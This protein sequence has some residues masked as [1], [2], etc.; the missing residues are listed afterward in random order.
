MVV[1][2]FQST[3]PTW[4]FYLPNSACSLALSYRYL[5]RSSTWKPWT[6][7]GTGRLKAVAHTLAKA[8]WR[9]STGWFRTSPR[10]SMSWIN[11]HYNVGTWNVGF[12][13]MFAEVV[14]TLS[15]SPPFP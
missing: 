10:G 3:V 7:P 11:Q 9:G 1:L 6:K 2:C 15:P 14:V 8:C 12:I 4:G 13:P 5:L